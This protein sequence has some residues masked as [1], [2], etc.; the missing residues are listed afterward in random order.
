LAARSEPHKPLERRRCTQATG[1]AGIYFADQAS[2]E[3][4]LVSANQQ[5][6]RRGPAI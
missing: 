4:Q 6:Q 5:A 1:L 3:Q 2:C